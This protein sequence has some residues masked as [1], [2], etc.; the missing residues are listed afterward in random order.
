MHHAL[1]CT[2]ALA[3]FSPSETP[4]GL[5]SLHLGS[6]PLPAL[7]H[8]SA[9]TRRCAFSLLGA[10]EGDR[11]CTKESQAHLKKSH[12]P[13]LAPPLAGTATA[14]FDTPRCCPLSLLEASRGRPPLHKRMFFENSAVRRAEGGL[15]RTTR[16]HRTGKKGPVVAGP[17][18]LITLTIYKNCAVDL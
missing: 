7:P 8:F 1:R 4:P 15:G 2:D 11:H 13:A 9:H 16:C 6:L 18:I 3:D 5:S 14:C 10:Y 17:Q 12:T